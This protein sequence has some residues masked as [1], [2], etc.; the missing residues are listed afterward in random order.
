VCDPFDVIAKAIH[1]VERPEK[2]FPSDRK[3][4][5]RTHRNVGFAFRRAGRRQFPV[6][7]EERRAAALTLLTV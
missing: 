3:D 2:L 7:E 6:V 5:E 1:L 4:T